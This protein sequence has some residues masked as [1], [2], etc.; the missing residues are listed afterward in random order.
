MGGNYLYG[1]S[2][3]FTDD[4]THSPRKDDMIAFPVLADEQLGQFDAYCYSHIPSFRQLY[5]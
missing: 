2:L 4:T 5:L 1:I 3:T